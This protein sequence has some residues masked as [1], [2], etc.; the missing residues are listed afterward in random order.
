MKR[1]TVLILAAALAGCATSG[2]NYVPVVDMGGRDA[3][4]FNRDLSECQV[5]AHQ[6]MNAAQGAMVGAVALG[7]LTSVL[8]PRGTKNYA[9]QQGAIVGG[10]A[11]AASANDTQETIV[12]R[13]LAGRG[14]TILD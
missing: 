6:R 7:I 9:A 14:W 10:V 3:A 4:R 1:I 5:Y 13:C 11:G 2:A 12:K 8:S